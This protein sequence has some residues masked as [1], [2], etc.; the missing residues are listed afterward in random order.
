MDS[1]PHGHRTLLLLRHAKSDWS[2][3]ESDP[4]RPLA[5]RGR[6]QAREAG[7]WL[8]TSDHAVELAVVSPAT[9]AASTWRLVAEELEVAP[10]TRVDDR[11][12]AASGSQ[13]LDLVRELPDELRTVVLVGHNPGVEDLVALLTGRRVSMPTS[14]F[15]VIALTGSWASAGNASA[16]IRAWGRP[17]TPT[18]PTA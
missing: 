14:A 18:P 12:Y 6:R 7:Q 4:D 10:P 17:P 8:S 2:G 5:K 1:T 13:L 9:R 11:V 15:A 3:H 16:P